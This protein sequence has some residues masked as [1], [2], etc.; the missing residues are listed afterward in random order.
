MGINKIARNKFEEL[1]LDMQ[2]YLLDLLI[3]LLPLEIVPEIILVVEI[4]LT[5]SFRYLRE[6]LKTQIS[7]EFGQVVLVY[8]NNQ[9]F[10]LAMNFIVHFPDQLNLL[11][12]GS[13]FVLQVGVLQFIRYV[14]VLVES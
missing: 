5:R 12:L 2:I 6:F 11:S 4:P 13:R 8:N 7:Q 3:V 14:S 10:A 9:L 1:L